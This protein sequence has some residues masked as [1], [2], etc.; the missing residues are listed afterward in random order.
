MYAWARHHSHFN[1]QHVA[2]DSKVRFI[3]KT[4]CADTLHSNLICAYYFLIANFSF[5]IMVHIGL[6]SQE[7][8]GLGKR[9]LTCC[10]K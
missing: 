7:S 3:H 2:Y 9:Y 10:V 6:E 1:S 8:F 5:Q 4:K